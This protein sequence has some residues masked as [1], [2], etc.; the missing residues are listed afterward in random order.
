[1]FNRF[2]LSALLTGAFVAA[3]ANASPVTYAFEFTLDGGLAQIAPTAGQFTYDA[4]ANGGS[5]LFTA[6]QITWAGLNFDLASAANNPTFH[7]A[8][9]LTNTA[10][11]S[12]ALL[13]QTIS[14]VSDG[15][16]AFLVSGGINGAAFGFAA[17]SNLIDSENLVVGAVYNG[18]QTLNAGGGYRIVPLAPVPEPAPFATLAISV[19]AGAFLCRR[20]VALAT[21]VR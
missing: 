21:P 7:N 15:W 19:A 12:F 13:S 18:N 11:S 8:C 1:L 10:N 14:C 9:G 5:G 16:N 3:T 17:G 20:R 2:F 6:F 4:S